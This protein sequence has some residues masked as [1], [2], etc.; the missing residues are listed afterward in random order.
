MVN[1]LENFKRYLDSVDINYKESG[2]S[3]AIEECPVCGDKR[4]IVLFRIRG[5]DPSK[6]LLGRCHTGVCQQ[7][8][9][10][11]SF[12]L[13]LGLSWEEA[14]E[15]HGTTPEKALKEL[16][17]FDE[18]SSSDPKK[19]NNEEKQIITREQI[20][21][22]SNFFSISDCDISKYA[23][24]R[25]YVNE[26]KDTFKVDILSRALVIIC[27][28]D[29][30]DP[31]GYQRRFL[32]NIPGI[33]KVKSS[34]DFPK[35]TS[36]LKFPKKSDILICEGPFTALSAWHY[37]YY[38]V[39]TWGSA[40]INQ[41]EKINQLSQDLGVNVAVSPDNDPA[42]ENYA[43]NIASYFHWKGKGIYTVS[44]EIGNDLNDSWQENR[45]FIK[46]DFNFDPAIPQ[47]CLAF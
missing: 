19:K 2:S 37:G 10:S 14:H 30:K 28:N 47:S 31:I 25:G 34:V 6:P 24:R 1:V 42:G 17:L 9:S 21:D 46:K 3:L 23:I 39:C 27:R 5:V 38:G 32:D 4:Y 16:T 43:R 35:T 12:L 7:N 41:L 36:L 13:K 8:Y 45:G 11:I 15:I 40:S 33:A 22:I 20:V 29:K 26:F 18:I 44:S